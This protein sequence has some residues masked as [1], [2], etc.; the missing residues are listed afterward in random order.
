MKKILVEYSHHFYIV[1]LDYKISKINIVSIEKYNDLKSTYLTDNKPI[2]T[3]LNVHNSRKTTNLPNNISKNQNIDEY[4]LHKFVDATQLPNTS[5]LFSNSLKQH[6]QDSKALIVDIIHDDQFNKPVMQLKTKRQTIKTLTNIEFSVATLSNK[7]IDNKSSI[8]T[9]KSLDSIYIYILNG[10]QMEYSH[11]IHITN[12]EETITN[13]H[14]TL[15]YIIRNY[16]D[17]IDKKIISLNKVDINLFKDS[18]NDLD[19]AFEQKDLFNEVVNSS[20]ELDH[21]Q[22]EVSLLAIGTYLSTNTT[23]NLYYKQMKAQRISSFLH[24]SVITVIL[25]LIS[26]QS[27]ILYINN[28]TIS[29]LNEQTKHIKQNINGHLLEHNDLLN[30]KQLDYIEKLVE[31]KQSHNI[32]KINNILTN[33]QGIAKELKYNK[34]GIDNKT[35]TLKCELSVKDKDIKN[36]NQLKYDIDTNFYMIFNSTKNQI[37]STID[38]KSNKLTI[39]TTNTLLGDS[40]E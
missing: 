23:S 4:L 16:S 7:Y 31:S 38:M 32:S 25:F 36:L 8:L 34:I 20:S 33:I 6:S 40:Y 30:I 26:Y 35:N 39:K 17:V 15:N 22:Q 19:I 24:N 1:T 11:C 5:I 2:Y 12:Q 13:I 9:F 27:F 14:N 28:Q 3:L 10:N 29:N 18:L 21:V 37:H